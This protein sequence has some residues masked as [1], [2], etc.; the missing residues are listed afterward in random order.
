M[1]ENKTVSYDNNHDDFVLNLIK[2]NT[3]NQAFGV[4]TSGN[5]LE[6]YYA[7]NTTDKIIIED[8]WTQSRADMAL[9]LT[10]RDGSE[11][12]MR[13]YNINDVMAEVGY[14]KTNTGSTVH[15]IDYDEIQA[16]LLREDHS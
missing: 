2:D 13:A 7:N 16:L 6:L 10:D 9:A 15:Y 14:T 5:N 4:K 12:Y 1:P 8:Y 3:T 11:T